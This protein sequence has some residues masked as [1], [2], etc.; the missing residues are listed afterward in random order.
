MAGN[1]S[2]DMFREGID[3]WIGSYTKVMA[4]Y[5]A[6]RNQ[7][8]ELL[9]LY[10]SIVLGTEID[11]S[12]SPDTFIHSRY[13]EA[14]SFHVPTTRP[15]VEILNEAIKGQILTKDLDLN[16]AKADNRSLTAGFNPQGI[17]T[18]KG[19][20]L[21]KQLWIS[22]ATMQEL[23]TQRG[24]DPSFLTEQLQTS[25]KPF[26]SFQALAKYVG[27]D[28]NLVDRGC[29]LVIV[30]KSP[31][32]IEAE[33]RFVD[34]EALVSI[35]LGKKEIPPSI[36]LG[37]VVMRGENEIPEEA[38]LSGKFTRATEEDPWAGSVKFRVEKADSLKLYLSRENKKLCETDLFP[39]R[40]I[41]QAGKKSKRRS[42]ERVFESVFD[43]YTAAG[44]QREGATG[45]V[46]KV[47]DDDGD[48]WAVKYLKP[49]RI[50]SKRAKRFRHEMAFCFGFR[51]DSIVR[52]ID[53][54]GVEVD[55]KI[56]PFYVMP[57]YEKNLR[58]LIDG[59]IDKNDVI[60]LYLELI[61]GLARVHEREIV[62][63]DIK[64]ENILY[65][66]TAEKLIMADFGVAH[67]A[68]EDLYTA[69]ETKFADRPMNFKYAAPEQKE[70]NGKVELQADIWAMG[71]ILNEMFTKN[72]FIGD[73]APTIGQFAPDFA[74]L[75]DV[76][77]A[78]TK[79]DP[80]KRPRNFTEVRR[81]I[82]GKG[83]RT[84]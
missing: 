82:R 5:I 8:G 3:S 51:H 11:I 81:L 6:V 20:Q 30:A 23:M 15:L 1:N 44:T 72:L 12:N 43:T 71:L 58:N 10:G 39:I 53:W 49:D 4:S 24:Y 36:H 32:R 45:F 35:S 68:E 26:N 78:M 14:G 83:V 29:S 38:D 13:I 17:D 52:V 75:D 46:L 21:Y 69:V 34:E 64:P 77:R 76:V 48:T 70:K 16:I 79:F 74:Y 25:R 62:H 50:N 9:L 2:V 54:G 73:D 47:K 57:F 55:K 33:S 59:G 37:Y 41:E 40:T 66:E 7:S 67:F 56:V 19:S 63:R 61:E 84:L 18:S 42:A 80:L 27:L 28:K 65:D 31:A 22:G 60:P